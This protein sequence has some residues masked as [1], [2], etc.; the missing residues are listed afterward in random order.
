MSQP[1]QISFHPGLPQQQRFV[2]SEARYPA[3]FGG[4]NNG[5][6]RGL[7]QRG[8]IHSLAHANNRG[9]LCRR[10]Y[11]EL[12]QTTRATFFEV[13][14]CNE[15]SAHDH[16][17]VHKWNESKNWL[18]FINGSEVLFRHLQ[19]ERAIQKLLSLNI[20][21]FGI[22]QAEEVAEAAWLTL[23]GR[24]GRVKE[25]PPPWGAIVGNPG[26]HDWIYRRYVANPNAKRE[27]YDLYQA[28]T[29]D[30][31][32]ADKDYIA[33]LY[34]KYP[35]HWVKRF[36]EG[37]WDVFI[38]QVFEEFDTNLHVIDP[39]PIPVDWRIGLGC[40]LGWNHPTAFV[41][42]AKDFDGNLFIYDEVCESRR[43]PGWFA[44]KLRSRG[45]LDM[46][47][48]QLPIYGPHDAVNT[49]GPSGTNY[50]AEYL[51]AG[52]VL[53]AGNQKP[54]VVGI[55]RMQR[56]FKPDFDVVGRNGRNGAPKCYIFKNCQD[57]IEELGTY[58]WKQLRPGDELTKEEPDEVVKVNDDRVDALRYL[59]MGANIDYVPERP[60]KKTVMEM[61]IE[62]L[63]KGIEQVPEWE[64]F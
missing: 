49:T 18:R 64:S 43:L 28:R 37:S 45:I 19:D 39:F 57:L 15:V 47:G 32:Y 34:S 21:W 2:L 4:I 14:G 41:W 11:E 17:L 16:P 9:I 3:Y 8:I 23:I 24:I 31:P 51:K 48:R 44:D 30:S 42:G 35:P 56:L 10:G 54:A 29:T 20:R 33:D 46:E 6:T 61:E 13:L 36:I 52:I 12:E 50:Q 59:V 22:D 38:G 55:T 60:R 26:G 5:K 1:I 53:S 7:T 27:G 62:A 40:D 25:G 63:M 58:R